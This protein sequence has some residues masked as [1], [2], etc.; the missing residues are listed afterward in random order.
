MGGM[1][2]L[3]LIPL[4]LLLAAPAR[5]GTYDL[6]TLS[7]AAPGTDGWPPA[8]NAPRGYVG[9]TA[10]PGGLAVRF[11]GRAL[12]DPGDLAEWVYTA[13]AD[14]AI[15]GWE[16]ERAVSGIGAG[17]WNVAFAAIGDGRVRY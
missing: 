3:I 8:V 4:F 2:L 17:S 11:G 16:I 1:R 6:Y 14:T 7:P 13:P 15:A 10:T 12:Y 5:A 9:M